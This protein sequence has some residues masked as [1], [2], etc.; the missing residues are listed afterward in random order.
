MNEQSINDISKAYI[1]NLNFSTTRIMIKQEPVIEN[2]PDDQ[3]ET[4]LFLPEGEGRQGE[5]GLRTQ[6]YF[7]KSLPDIPLI[8]VITVV[9]NGEKYLEETI[10][11]VLGQTYDNVEYIIIDGA[12]TD[13]TLD[14]IRKYEHA[15]DYWVSEKDC[16]IYDAMNKGIIASQGQIIGI[17]NSD[18]YYEQDTCKMVTKTCKNNPDAY[19]V[20]GAMRRIDED[21]NVDSVYGSKKDFSEILMAPFNHPACFF[22]AEF[23]RKYGIFDKNFVTAADYDLMLRFKGKNL[24]DVYID[25]VLSNFR[26]VGTTSQ[27]SLFPA[28][29]IWSLLRKN[30]YSYRN[31]VYACSYRMLIWISSRILKIFRLNNLKSQL[32]QYTSYHKS[33]K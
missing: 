9:F 28:R 29:Q 18:D 17:V 31:C 30:E 15:I 1:L 3:F 14:V 2:H 12:S 32:R 33:A 23:Y 27:L 20:H 22:H 25:K 26:K 5:G 13:G 11:S 6:G 4:K 7:K 10:Q 19:L 16:G 8:S 21:K 24:K